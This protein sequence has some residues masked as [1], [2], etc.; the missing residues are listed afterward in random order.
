MVVLPETNSK[1]TRWISWSEFVVRANKLLDNEN[2]AVQPASLQDNNKKINY[3]TSE[4][5]NAIT[6]E[7][8]KQRTRTKT[9]EQGARTKPKKKRGE[10][11]N[12]RARTRTTDN[13]NK[14][15]RNGEQQY[16]APSL[17][18]TTSFVQDLWDRLGICSKLM[19]E[20]RWRLR[21]K[22]T[23]DN[24]PT[25]PCWWRG[26]LAAQFSPRST[27]F[28]PNHKEMCR[29]SRLADA[30]QPWISSHL[31]VAFNPSTYLARTSTCCMRI[32]AD[33]ADRSQRRTL[34]SG[35]SRRL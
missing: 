29:K 30:E 3:T 25:E 23:N 15:S 26:E 13:K 9:A 22:F 7:K 18:A 35:K 5:N 21:S 1:A 10:R 6:S 24:G 11:E 31:R 27:P 12:K 16:V 32:N 14:E 17:S 2:G 19:L 4:E 28:G 8:A 34:L 33:S 20:P